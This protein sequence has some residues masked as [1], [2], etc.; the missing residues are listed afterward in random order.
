[1]TKKINDKQSAK[2][3]KLRLSKVLTSFNVLFQVPEKD[4][5]SIR[6]IDRQ[7]FAETLYFALNSVSRDLEKL[8]EN[9]EFANIIYEKI[10]DA[11][12]SIDLLNMLALECQKNPF[13]ENLESGVL[14]L[15]MAQEG[16]A[17][18]D[19]ALAV[20]EPGL[21]HMLKHAEQLFE[22]ISL[23]IPDYLDFL[24][25]LSTVKTSLPR[26]SPGAYNLKSKDNL[27]KLSRGRPTSK[28]V[29]KMQLKAQEL[30]P[31]RIGRAFRYFDGKFHSADLTSIRPVDKFY[32]YPAAR[33]LFKTY[34]DNFSE[35][36]VNLPLLISSFPGLGKTHFTIS[37][38]LS[39]EELILVLPEPGDLEKPL[40][41]LIR[42]LGRKKNHK[43]VLFFDDVDTRNINWYYFRTNIGG[44]FV[45]P[46]NITVVI[47]SNYGFPANISSRG[48]GLEFE[49]FDDVKCQ[50]MVHDFLRAMGMKKPMPEL[51]SVISAD[52]V[53]EFGQ[54]MFEELSPRTLVRYLERY[55]KNAEKRKRTL[56][57]AHELNPILKYFLTL[58]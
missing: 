39:Y 54:K 36:K 27:F 33:R 34:F 24:K 23:L 55:E 45:L 32:G 41:K 51:V 21:L 14:D 49:M 18:A 52:Y 5:F 13:A 22:N 12:D 20:Q 48:R 35:K 11:P 37:Y 42:T 30:D 53:E 4:S 56:E 6:E 3:L 29:K 28:A 8:A 44:S 46:S 16:F 9:P 57:M 38:T 17:E 31:F 15:L 40:E 1:M 2:E 25:N 19:G 10:S 50:E 7:N 58:I 43:F 47:A 26:I